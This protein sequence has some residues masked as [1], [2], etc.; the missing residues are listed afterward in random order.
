M[1]IRSAVR[2]TVCVV[3][4][5]E[6]PVKVTR[7]CAKHSYRLRTY[8][9]LRK[10]VV[11]HTCAVVGCNS[12]EHCRGYCSTHHNRLVRYGDPL[13]TKHDGKGKTSAGYT[14][15]LVDG[16]VYV[17]EHRLVMEK[18]LGRPLLHNETVHHKN[19][20]RGDNR[21]ENLELWASRHSRG[22]RVFDLVDWA[23]KL[24]EEYSPEL[25]R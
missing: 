4:W 13:F 18:V 2:T 14:E 3:P 19:G 24:L 1:K 11:K 12:K 20:M 16:G 7:M 5:C 21:P 15:V 17:R 9:N 23:V 6:T 8:G 25:L 22:Q 10:I